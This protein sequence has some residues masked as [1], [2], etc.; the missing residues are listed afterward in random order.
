MT[1]I[2]QNTLNAIEVIDAVIHSYP[3]P[4]R[5]KIISRTVVN[6]AATPSSSEPT[7]LE[8]VPDVSFDL[9][10]QASPSPSP[11]RDTSPQPPPLTAPGRKAGQ[12]VAKPANAE[13]E[14]ARLERLLA[15]IAGWDQAAFEEFYHAT[16]RKLFATALLIVKRRDLA[17]EVVQDAYV[18]IWKNAASYNP[19]CGSAIA[20]S[21]TVTRNLAIDIV[22]RPKLNIE[23][24]EQVLPEVPADCRTALEELEISQ[25]NGHVMMALQMLDPFRRSLIVAAYVHGE[26]REQIGKRYGKSTNTIK[27]LIRRGLLEL[28]ARLE[29]MET[30]QPATLPRESCRRKAS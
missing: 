20:W 10:D 7:G 23:P 15:R 19:C 3:G 8:A 12:P 21:A 16:K 25:T 29:K 30:R 24:D 13:S 1:L 6:R 2:V 28:R 26:N 18:R 27:T 5:R 9:L 22:R 14:T 11:L 4:F 17:E